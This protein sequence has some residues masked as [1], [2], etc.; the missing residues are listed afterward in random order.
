MVPWAPLLTPE[1]VALD[2]PTASVAWRLAARA[3]D[4]AVSLLAY[5][6][7]VGILGAAL[8]TSNAGTTFLVVVDLLGGFTVVLLY[9]VLTE[10]FCRGRTLGKLAVGLR[11]VRVD[12]GPIYFAQAGVRGALGLIDVWGTLGGLGTLVIFLSKRDQRL[13]D[14][15]AGT[16]VLRQRRGSRTLAPVFIRVPPGCEQLVQTIDVGAMTAEDYELVRSFLVRWAD[17][18]DRR[19]SEIAAKLAQP[20]WLRFKHPLPA[21]I[22]PDYYLACLGSAYQFRH[23][24]NFRALPP[25]GYAPGPPPGYAPGPPPG[26]APP[27]PPGYAPPPPPPPPSAG[28]GPLPPAIPVAAPAWW[29]TAPPVPARVSAPGWGHTSAHGGAAGVDNPPNWGDGDDHGGSAGANGWSPPN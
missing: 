10:A 20:L 1:A 21:G 15:A 28:W 24:V 23:P 14:M 6:L 19:R 29:G 5:S 17:F 3:I 2:L 4:V 22:G 13:G 27:P 16:L 8:G 12:G 9:P 11:V 25:P 7:V 26:Y 18:G